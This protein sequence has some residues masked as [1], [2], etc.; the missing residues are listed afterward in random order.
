MNHFFLVLVCLSLLV[1]PVTASAGKCKVD[2]NTA[3]AKALTSLKGIGPA[4]AKKIITYR[5]A[6]RTAATKKG[7]KTW[8]FNNWKTLMAV[9]GITKQVCDA[10]ISHVGF[11]GKLQKACPK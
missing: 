8:N 6:K 3:S 5:Q 2:V 10:N 7:K 9:P 4:L 11:S 1:I